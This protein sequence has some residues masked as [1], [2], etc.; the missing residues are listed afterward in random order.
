MRQRQRDQSETETETGRNDVRGRRTLGG[1]RKRTSK[2]HRDILRRM[3]SV[4]RLTSTSGWRTLGRVQEIQEH[5]VPTDGATVHP[6]IPV[7][8][9]DTTSSNSR[10]HRIPVYSSPCVDLRNVGKLS[11]KDPPH[12]TRVR[13]QLGSYVVYVLNSSETECPEC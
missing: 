4:G 10:N 7:T 3:G 11:I 6:E 13:I 1:H 12:E 5:T 9:K 2:R 8:L